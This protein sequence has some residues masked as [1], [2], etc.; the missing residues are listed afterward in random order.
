MPSLLRAE[1]ILNDSQKER[2]L[3][4]S[5]YE[6]ADGQEMPVIRLLVN[7]KTREAYRKAFSR[8]VMPKAFQ[9]GKRGLEI[10]I[11]DESLEFAL[12]VLRTA[13]IA[14]DNWIDKPTMDVIETYLKRTSTVTRFIANAIAN[15]FDDEEGLKKQE[16]E[17][18]EKN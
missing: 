16:E 2:T 6:L 11:K 10:Q 5:C 3:E 8:H 12:S 1:D 4:L 9:R 7:D 15:I 13:M 14:A 17:E 18:D